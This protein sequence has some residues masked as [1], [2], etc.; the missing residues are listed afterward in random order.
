MYKGISLILNVTFFYLHV[1]NFKKLFLLL[2]DSNLVLYLVSL[3][4]SPT[5]VPVFCDPLPPPKYSK[6]ALTTGKLNLPQ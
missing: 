6:L 5:A 1:G 3:R 2:N 4:F